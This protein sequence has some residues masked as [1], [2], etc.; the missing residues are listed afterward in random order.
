MQNN[1]IEKAKE[2]KHD[3]KTN[4]EIASLLGVSKSTIKRW[5]TGKV[6]TPSTVLTLQVLPPAP[7]VKSQD[8]TNDIEELK[9]FI[10]GLS[11]ITFNTPSLKT[12]NETPNSIAL[13]IGDLHFGSH[14][15]KTIEIFYQVCRELKPQTIILNGDTLD[16]FSISRYPKDIRISSSLLKERNAYHIFLKNIHDITANYQTDIFET[17][18]NHSGDSVEGRYWRYLS[19]R[20]GELSELP[21]IKDKLSYS[22]VFHPTEDWSRI[23]LVDYVEICKGF[24]VLHGDVVRKH[25]GYSARGLLDKWFVSIVSNH[26]HRIGSTAQRFPSIGSQKERI[27]RVYE[28]GCACDLEPCYASAANWQNGFSIINYNNTSEP[29]VETVL[30]HNG[31]ATVGALGKTFYAK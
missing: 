20:I 1:P 24:V 28:N 22:N 19:D 2:L 6:K 26:T 21:E 14:S 23:K 30:V 13:V 18:S 9:D 17:N 31:K 8:F 5:I 12:L 29:S 16:M 27:I 15:D 25:G 7:Y 4:R 3:G 11:P 10:I